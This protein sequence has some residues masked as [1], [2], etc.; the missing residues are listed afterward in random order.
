MRTNVELDEI[1]IK[2]AMKMSG[3]H[4]KKAVIHMALQEYIKMNKRKQILK[5]QGQN[6]WEGDLEEMRK[7]R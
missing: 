7:D 5:Y 4:T 6:I 2:E 3:I 1:L